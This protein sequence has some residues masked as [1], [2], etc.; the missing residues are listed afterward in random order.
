MQIYC[1]SSAEKI[2]NSSITVAVFSLSEFSFPSFFFWDFFL[3]CLALLHI[4]PF[5]PVI[6]TFIF[7]SQS[8]LTSRFVS[9][10]FLLILQSSMIFSNQGLC[11]WYHQTLPPDLLIEKT[12]GHYTHRDF[13]IRRWIARWYQKCFQLL[14]RKLNN[15]NLQLVI[16]EEYHRC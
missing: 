5:L 1:W 10:T 16:Q 14:R 13:P 8:W 7:F 11:L 12:D 15:N 6:K 3:L 2:I 4:V 9:L